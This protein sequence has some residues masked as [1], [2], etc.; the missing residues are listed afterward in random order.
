MA[1]RDDSRISKDD[2]VTG[3]KSRKDDDLQHDIRDFKGTEEEW[4]RHEKDQQKNS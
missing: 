4:G 1:K 2:I 3:H